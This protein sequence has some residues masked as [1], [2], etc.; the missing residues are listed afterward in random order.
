MTTVVLGLLGYTLLLAAA[1]PRLLAGASWPARAPRVALLLWHA[2]GLSVLMALIAATTLLSLPAR[3]LWRG[4]DEVARACMGMVRAT[5][6]PTSLPGVVAP[7]ALGLLGMVALRIVLV[8]AKQRRRTHRWRR[9]HRRGLSLLPTD[10][11]GVTV[12]PHSVPTVYTLPGRKPRVVMTSATAT[13]LTPAQRAAAEAHERAHIDGR[14]HVALG[15]ARL[16]EQALP[17]VPL[18]HVIRAQTSRLLE[19]AADDRAAACHGPHALLSA[20]AAVATSPV[21]GEAL[22]VSGADP[23]ERVQRLLTPARPA[24][25][26]WRAT[27]T[28]GAALLLCLPVLAVV[29]PVVA[30]IAL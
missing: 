9:E 5:Y 2:A 11:N 15:L 16:L 8:G 30:T 10:A 20:I 19:M 3:A 23:V 12:V 7:I 28:A 14:H 13:R 17:G 25:V 18:F 27:A 4:V 24:S 22:G 21:P 6:C 26:T 29:L 1:V